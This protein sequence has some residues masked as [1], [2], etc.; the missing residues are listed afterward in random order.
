MFNTKKTSI[1]TGVAG[2]I[3]SH[4]AEQ[5][6]SK[7]HRVIG[8]DSF[9]NYYPSKIK[10]K[11]LENCL[12]NNNFS[13]IK[14]DILDMDLDSLF[15]KSNLL[16]HLAA[17]SGVRTSWEKDFNNYVKNNILATQKI[18]ESAKNKKTFDKIIIAS[19]SSIY[20][21]QKN[22]ISEETIPKPV[23]PYGVSKLASEN[24]SFSYFKNFNLPIIILRYFTVYGP[25]QRPDMAFC[26]FINKNLRNEE[27]KIFGDG[28]QSRDFTYVSDIVN[29]TILASECNR[30]GSI[31]N[32]GGDKNYSL[33]ETIPIIENITG[34][35]MKVVFESKQK[36]DVDKTKTD[37]SKAKKILNYSPKTSLKQGLE[38][39]VK[40]IKKNFE[41]YND[42]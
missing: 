21:N 36:G 41:L 33:L 2:F 28:T 5:L 1:V 23:S 30:N 32:I 22:T 40:D 42:V 18:L 24:L 16:F 6:L 39:Q 38:E 12:K 19:S 14:N 26:R 27:I 29:A 10:Y 4:L 15:D 17:Q 25:K 9:T 8:I 7:N 20:G 11:N 31:F 13:L 3:G 37:I 35:K 34:R